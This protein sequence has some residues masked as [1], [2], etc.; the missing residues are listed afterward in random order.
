MSFIPDNRICYGSNP[1]TQTSKKCLLSGAHVA[2][3]SSKKPSEWAKSYELKLFSFSC[4][5]IITN[6][7]Q[8]DT[9]QNI[10]EHSPPLEPSTPSIYDSS[11]YQNLQVAP[12]NADKKRK[13][14]K[15]ISHAGTKSITCMSLHIKPLPEWYDAIVYFPVTTVHKIKEWKKNSEKRGKMTLN[16]EDAAELNLCRAFFK[17]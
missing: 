10:N 12:E 16:L 15:L 1:I 6:L 4:Y 11:K 2:S 3:S 17:L 9:T 14:V 8:T 13:A 7:G 5:V